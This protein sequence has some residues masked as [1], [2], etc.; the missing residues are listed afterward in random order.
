MQAEA[1]FGITIKDSDAEK[2]VTPHDLIEQ[3]M[4][5]VGRTGQVP[6]LKQRAFHR[7][8]ATLMRRFGLKRD[9]IR[10]ETRLGEL[11]PRA[12]RKTHLTEFQKE[13]DIDN[14]IDLI[15]PAWLTS[16]LSG[17]V[18]II[19]LVVTTYFAG[20]NLYAWLAE[21]LIFL[22][23]FGWLA[24]ALTRGQRYEFAPTIATVEGFSR[25][26]VANPSNLVA[27]PPG[28]WSREQVAEK[29]R[30]IVIGVLG[31]EKEYR[32]DARFV[33]DLGVG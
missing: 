23:V 6:C 5:Q 14:N 10:L 29:V 15:R 9:R 1:D 24:A 26:V 25:W 19:S 8:R 13:L 30:S 12:G 11:V 33:E 20:L 17:A 3:I 2:M 4:S 27:V 22:G 18:L 7:I 21:F 32:E 16:I 28:Q 31:C